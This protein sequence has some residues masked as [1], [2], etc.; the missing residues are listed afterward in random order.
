MA[1]Q[2]SIRE[3]QP[4]RVDAD[5]LPDAHLP[6]LGCLQDL[7]GKIHLA[8]WMDAIGLERRCVVVRPSAQC[9]RTM[10]LVAFAGTRND[11][12][13]SYQD[14]PDIGHAP[15]IGCAIN[16]SRMPCAVT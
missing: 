3:R 6:L 7:P 15:A 9:A 10:G 16:P 2:P 1:G 8:Q 12:D 5:A 4:G 13:A 14:L 11:S